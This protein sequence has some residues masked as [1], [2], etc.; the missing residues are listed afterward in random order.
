M[1]STGSEHRYLEFHIDGRPA[2]RLGSNRWHEVDFGT[3][4]AFCLAGKSLDTPHNG[5]L[6][7]F[8][9]GSAE[10]MLDLGF[11]R[12]L[13]YRDLQH[14]VSGIQLIREIRNDLEV[15][16]DPEKKKRVWQNKRSGTYI[17]ASF[18]LTKLKAQTNQL[19]WS[20]LALLGRLG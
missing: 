8:I 17:K 1:H 12:I 7:G 6:F 18:V 16:R 4:V 13:W 3:D 14:H 20:F 9:L 5:L 10:R 2:P 15:D 19:T 11:R